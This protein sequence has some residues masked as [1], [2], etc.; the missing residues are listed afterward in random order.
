MEYKEAYQKLER[1]GQLPLLKYYEELGQAEQKAL[2]AQIAQ[3]DFS[4]L[5]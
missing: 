5:E 1:Y 3:T 4:V 2:L